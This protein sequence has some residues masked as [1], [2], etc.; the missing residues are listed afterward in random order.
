MPAELSPRALISLAD[1]KAYC[2]LTTNAIDDQ[3]TGLINAASEEVHELA[4]REIVAANAEWSGAG[5]D[6]SAPADL[7]ILPELRT[8]DL[9]GFDWRRRDLWIEDLQ[10]I[11]SVSLDGVTVSGANYT[12]RRDGRDSWRPFE[13]IRFGPNVGLV[14]LPGLVAVTG[15]WG[16]PEIPEALKQSTREIVREKYLRDFAR[17]SD[18]AEL[19]DGTLVVRIPRSIPRDAFDRIVRFRRRQLPLA[20]IRIGV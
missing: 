14:S 5:R 8:W 1:A 13:R 17:K 6:P 12:L 4:Q 16:F 11:V 18:T 7:E 20:S 15:R 10:E 19:E 9:S 2:K 3:V